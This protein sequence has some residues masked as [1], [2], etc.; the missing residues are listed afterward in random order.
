[1]SEPSFKLYP[2][3][4]EELVYEEGENSYAFQ[5]GWGVSPPHVEVPA[6]QDWDAMMPSF[7]QGRRDEMLKLLREKSGHVIEERPPRS[8]QSR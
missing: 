6:A 3:W 1:M 7:L 4:K 8:P 2:K 5:C